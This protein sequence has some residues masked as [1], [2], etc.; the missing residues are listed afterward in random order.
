MSTLQN[1][2]IGFLLSIAF[3]LAAFWLV[4]QHVQGAALFSAEKLVVLLVGLA[5]A[6]LYVQLI[7]FLHLGAEKQRP[8]WSLIIFAFAAVVVVVL[9]GGTIWI[10]YHLDRGHTDL[11]EI[12]PSGT[13][14][15]Q[16]QDD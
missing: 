1:Y 16:T 9:V 14:S 6:Q 12:Y 2:S 11:S 10:M 7:C 15:P 13:V 4:W 5:V 8:R 3:T